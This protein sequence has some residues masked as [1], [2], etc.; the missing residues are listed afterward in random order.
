MVS[1]PL[2]LIDKK[3]VEVF[4]ARFKGYMECDDVSFRDIGSSRMKKAGDS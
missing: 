3:V 4:G 1:T 2:L